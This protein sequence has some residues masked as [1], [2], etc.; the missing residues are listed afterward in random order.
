M[1]RDMK[2]E[3]IL[4]DDDYHLKVIDFGDAN[5]IVDDKELIE[6]IKKMEL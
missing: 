5:Y 6:Q 1:H 3:N 2:P 4:L